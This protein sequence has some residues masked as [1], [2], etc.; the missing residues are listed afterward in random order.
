MERKFSSFSSSYSVEIKDVFRT[1]INEATGD[2]DAI[3]VLRDINIIYFECKTGA[4]NTDKILKC[5]DRAI[6]LHCE[7]SIMLIHGTINLTSLKACV[8]GISHPFISEV[9]LFEI[10]IKGKPSSNVIG[11]NTCYFVSADGNIEEQ[12]R[13]IMR[14]NAAQKLSHSNSWLV[15][16]E[17]FEKWGYTRTLIKLLS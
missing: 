4:F 1:N 17:Q 14:I 11:W 7:F 10:E 6:A 3:V 2:Y 16:S 9:E 15:P 13:T 8:K 12:I 5:F